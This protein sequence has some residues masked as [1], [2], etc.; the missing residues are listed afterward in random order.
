MSS[1]R[2]VRMARNQSMFRAVNERVTAW[3]ERRAA[4][5]TEKLMFYCECADPKCFDRVWL[6]SPEYEALRRDSTRFAVLPEHV[7]P[8]VERVVAEPD[9][10]AVV[11]KNEDLRRILE[12]IDPRRGAYS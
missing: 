4:P 1:R 2:T 10:Y 11:E 7:Y 5:A 9:G 12:R 3:P 6:T 8:E